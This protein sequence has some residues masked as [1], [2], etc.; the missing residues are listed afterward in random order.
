MALADL[1]AEA[2]SNGNPNAKNPYS[3]AQG[4]GQFT[5]QTW[6][7]VIRQHRPDL[8]AGRSPQDILAM[9]SDPKLSMQMID[10]L[11]QD[12]SAYLRQ[13]GLP[14][15]PGTVYLAHFAGPQGAAAVLGGDDAAPASS[16]LSPDAVRANPFL[17]NMTVGDL[18]AW[19]SRKVGGGQMP[20]SATKAPAPDQNAA[21]APDPTV[22]ALSGSSGAAAPGAPPPDLLTMA[23]GGPDALAAVPAMLR[24]SEQQMPAPPQ[25]QQQ[26]NFPEPPGIARAR[27]LARAMYR[28]PVT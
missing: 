14:V 4:L 10:A 15:N 11:A 2:E 26:I 27:L 13:R 20:A 22:A 17:A 16:V 5:N 6:L 23:S 8:V 9:R 28:L 19:A 21:P 7:N 18:K 3:S 25:Q 12:N 1:I 24:A